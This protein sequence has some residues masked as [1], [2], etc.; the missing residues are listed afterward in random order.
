M[1]DTEQIIYEQ[2]SLANTLGWR[3]AGSPK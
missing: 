3:Y 2:C 1:F